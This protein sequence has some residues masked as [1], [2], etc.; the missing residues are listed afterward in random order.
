VG[1]PV[2]ES[3][4]E[5]AKERSHR[6]YQEWRSNAIKSGLVKD[7]LLFGVEKTFST[8]QVGRF[9]GRSRQWVYQG[10]KPDKGGVAPFSYQDGTPIIPERVPMGSLEKRAWTLPDIWEIAK[11][12]HRRTN[13]DDQELEEI[14]AKIMVAEFGEA[15]F[16]KGKV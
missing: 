8:V 4:Q 15:A 3:K 2:T 16:K 10:M 13:I 7:V 9:F 14:M 5:T 6:Q 11:A 1:I 12:W